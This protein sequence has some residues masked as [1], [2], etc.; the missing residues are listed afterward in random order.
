MHINRIQIEYLRLCWI[1]KF[2]L[3]GKSRILLVLWRMFA[4]LQPEN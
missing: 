1:T 2:Y 3:I 4:Y